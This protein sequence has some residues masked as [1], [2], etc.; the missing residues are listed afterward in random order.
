MS[1]C[2]CQHGSTWASQDCGAHPTHLG[3]AAS[4]AWP[5]SGLWAGRW[6]CVK[7]PAVLHAAYL[8]LGQRL[9]RSCSGY[10]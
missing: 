5:T 6:L 7:L 8:G 1:G 9:T 3:I 10:H 2:A 4:P